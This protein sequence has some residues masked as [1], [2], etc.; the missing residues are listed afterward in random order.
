VV[1][2]T[3]SLAHPASAQRTPAA[4]KKLNTVFI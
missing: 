2:V 3:L 4:K 1:T